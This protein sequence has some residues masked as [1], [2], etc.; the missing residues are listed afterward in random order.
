[1]ASDSSSFDGGT[2]W[3]PNATLDSN[4][5]VYQKDGIRKTIKPNGSTLTAAYSLVGNQLTLG[6]SN[7]WTVEVL[8]TTTLGVKKTLPGLTVK[9]AFIKVQ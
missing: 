1:M 3:T 2:S 7:L 6:V 5:Y 8:N 4:I 9:Q